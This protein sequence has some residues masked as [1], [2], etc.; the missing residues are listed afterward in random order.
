MSTIKTLA[1]RLRAD[2][3]RQ[4]EIE[5]GTRELLLCQGTWATVVYRMGQW[6]YE[7]RRPPHFIPLKLAY[8]LVSKAIEV[9]CG[10]SVPASVKIGPGLYIG[11]FGEIIIH[12]DAVIGERFSIGQ[13]CTIGTRGQGGSDV[14]VIGDNVYLGVGSKVLG[15]IRIGDNVA[16]GANAVV[17]KDV[18][19]DCI[20]VGVPAKVLPRKGAGR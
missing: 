11:H 7:K 2:L 20:A 8:Q 1:E 9:T 14:P 18:P 6:I 13:G 15:G 12:S 5:G 16:V 19:D 4:A 3:T 10:I 17:V